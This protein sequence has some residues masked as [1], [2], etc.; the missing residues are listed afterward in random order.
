M[1]DHDKPFLCYRNGWDIKIVPANAA[2]WWALCMWVAPVLLGSAG[3]MVA[4][5][6][7]SRATTVSATMLFILALV[8]WGILMTRWMMV[9]SKMV[10]L[11]E[12]KQLTRQ[13]W[14]GNR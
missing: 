9:R 13:F 10:S 11:E 1:K 7:A 3:F 6:K 14:P 5:T 8:A 4:I 2:G 12:L